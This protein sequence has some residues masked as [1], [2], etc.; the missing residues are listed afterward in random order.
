MLYEYLKTHYQTNEPIFLSDVIL[1]DVTNNYIRQMFKQ[2]CDCGKLMRFNTG[3]YYLPEQGRSSIT[4]AISAEA[5]AMH[6]YISRGT[7]V[8]GYYS[9]Q[10][11][12][13]QINLTSRPVNL[14]E[15]VSN[16]AGGKY[17]EI[18]LGDSKIIL[19]KM[20][21]KKVFFKRFFC[22]EF[23]FFK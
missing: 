9:G 1:P 19:R 4:S 21:R 14:L 7:D 10:T 8:Y 16:Y 12:A 15:I 18:T 5:V 22:V 23:L 20:K 2:L 17:R 13:A 6:K 11:F 3:I